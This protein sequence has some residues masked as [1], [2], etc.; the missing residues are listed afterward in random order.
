MTKINLHL[1]SHHS[2]FPCLPYSHTCNNNS[3][4]GPK[5]T[6]DIVFF[7]RAKVTK[8]RSTEKFPQPAPGP[9]Q[10]LHP[11]NASSCEC[12][13]FGSKLDQNGMKSGSGHWLELGLSSAAGSGDLGGGE[14]VAGLVV[15]IK[16]TSLNQ[17]N[18]AALEIKLLLRVF[19]R[20]SYLTWNLSSYR[21][22]ASHRHLITIATK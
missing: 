5:V 3:S 14:G 20:G 21:C 18:I 4:S 6:Y 22:G 8:V 17:Q 1:S 19:Q 7:S 13:M 9:A 11:V 16:R 2:N 15:V 12:W 10:P